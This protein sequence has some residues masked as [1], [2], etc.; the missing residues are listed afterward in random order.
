MA[1]EIWEVCGG[2]ESLAFKTWPTFDPMLAKDDLITMA[3]Q[4]NGKTRT[5][6][7]VPAGISQADFMALAKKE[8]KLLKY[9]E[10]AQIVKEVFIAGKICNLI[11]K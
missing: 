3:V 6:L 5:T 8:E 7:D 10:N 2:K 1:E 11:V 9:L 4:I